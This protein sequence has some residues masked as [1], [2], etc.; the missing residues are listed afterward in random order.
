MNDQ[1]GTPA[2]GT[3]D[4]TAFVVRNSAHAIGACTLR[5]GQHDQAAALKI[6]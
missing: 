2:R 4:P 6:N 1:Q 5:S 3:Q